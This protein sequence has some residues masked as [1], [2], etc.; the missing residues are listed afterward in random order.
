MNNLKLSTVEKRFLII[1]ILLH[2]FAL[3]VNLAEVSGKI[4]RDNFL[5][6][7]TDPLYSKNGFWPFVNFEGTNYYPADGNVLYFNGLFY[8][9]GLSAFIFYILLGIGIVY[10]PKLWKEQTIQV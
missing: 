1:W 3:F 5:F 6:T 9:Y 2:S 10:I 7:N 8:S 4:D